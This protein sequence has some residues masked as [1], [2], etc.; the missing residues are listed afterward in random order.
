MKKII[1][2]L[3]ISFFAANYLSAQVVIKGDYKGG[4][5]YV[6]AQRTGGKDLIEEVR[7]AP[8]TRLEND[9]ASLKKQMDDL[10]KK[11]NKIKAENDRLKRDPSNTKDL[12]DSLQQVQ[13]RLAQKEEQLNNMKVEVENLNKK[14]KEMETLNDSSIAV[15]E[16]Q[17]EDLTLRIHSKPQNGNYI[18]LDME[19]GAAR[20]QNEYLSNSK[21]SRPVTLSPQRFSVTYTYYFSPQKPMA[22]K[23]GL[24]FGSY[25]SRA[26]YYSEGHI[27]TIPGQVDIDG[28]KYDLLYSYNNVDEEIV[29]NYL[30]VPLLLHIGNSGD[31]RGIQAWCDLGVSLSMNVGKQF[32][33]AGTYTKRGYY[34]KW[35]VVIS[36][37]EELGFVDGDV[38][39]INMGD[40]IKVNPFVVWGEVAAG[41][42]IPLDGEKFSIGVAGNCRYSLTPVSSN[43]PTTGGR[44]CCLPEQPTMLSGNTRILTLGASVSFA[45]K[46]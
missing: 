42:S 32:R 40:K 4:T 34:K 41:V 25:H 38:A 26:T 46:F 35:N 43:E 7:Y 15:L 39:D 14:L 36:N 23:A 10:K 44:S 8:L 17:V 21:W 9:V 5:L 24:A 30:S 6:R 11:Y 28:D 19:L 18:S 37:V 13:Q 12:S 29:L 45:Y 20:F 16:K 22:L 1:V 2:L 31:G 33:G 27:D 3:L